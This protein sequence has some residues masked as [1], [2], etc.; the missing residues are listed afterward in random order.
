MQYS[1]LASVIIVAWNSKA[2]LHTCLD[3]LLAQ[4]FHD[5]EVILVDNGSD[6]GAL[7]GLRE[8]YP[9]LDLHIHRLNSNLGF[10]VANNGAVAP[11]RAL[12]VEN[13]WLSSMRMHSPNLTGSKN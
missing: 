4:T 1:P 13:G 8:K 12:R 2:Y 9:A 7:E 11:A 3:K 5:F 6:D 10:A